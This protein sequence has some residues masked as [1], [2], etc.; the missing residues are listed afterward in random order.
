[1]STLTES[2]WRVWINQRRGLLGGVLAALLFGVAL[3]ACWHLLSNLDAQS[4]RSALF[5]VPNQ[6]LLGAVLA[7]VLG[8]ICL[9]GYEWSAAHYA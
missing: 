7:T 4:L 3:I 9:L 6:A 1:M 5:E 2:S 8:F